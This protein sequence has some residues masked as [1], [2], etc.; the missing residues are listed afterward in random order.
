V[1]RHSA[2][3]GALAQLFRL[4]LH[5][6]RCADWQRTGAHAASAPCS[7]CAWPAPLPVK[8]RRRHCLRLCPCAARA[9]RRARRGAEPGRR[10]AQAL[11]V[12]APL[13][14]AHRALRGQ[15]I[16]R[17]CSGNPLAASAPWKRRDLHRLGQA[18]CERLGGVFYFRILGFNVRTCATPTHPPP[19]PP[20]L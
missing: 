16:P 9:A 5:S 8:H 2:V 13:H 7:T 1:S 12:L 10:G 14:R 15:G 20:P 4:T 11:A 3:L 6:A 18:D 19:A 17:A